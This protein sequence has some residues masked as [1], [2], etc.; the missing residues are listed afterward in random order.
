[1]NYADLRRIMVERQ[2][3][4]RGIT[5]KRVLESFRKVERHK[6][7]P[8]DFRENAYEDY[9]LPIGENQTISQP[10]MAALMTQCLRLAGTEKI[11]EIGT[12]SGYQAAILSGLAKEIYSLER[13]SPLAKRAGDLLKNLGYKNVTCGVGDG[14]LGWK[15]HAP[16]DGII[17]TAASP[18]IPGAYTG[19]LAEGGRIVIP[20]GP[21]SSQVLTLIEKGPGGFTSSDICGCVFVPLLG[22]EG[23]RE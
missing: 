13:I 12:G 11:L 2:L 14:T 3:L 15:D 20:L 23:W 6:F 19:Q 18:K 9:P 1:M 10:Y 17:V 8:E 22:K 4:P 5:D 21:S 16:F 7:V